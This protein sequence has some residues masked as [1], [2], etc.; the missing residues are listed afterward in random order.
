MLTRDELAAAYAPADRRMPHVRMNFVTSLDGAATLG[1][2]SGALGGETDRLLMGVLR[3]QCDVLLVG[4]G[5]I[6]AEGYG[7][8]AVPEAEALVRE[9][10]GLDAQPRVAVVSRTLELSPRH[11][12]FAD[13]VT[14]PLVVTC[15]A[16]SAE[17][18]A[19]LAA[20]ADVIVAGSD[21][22][23]LGVALAELT[24]RGL[25][26]VLCEG[27]P[28]L[29]GSLLAAGLVDEVCLTVSPHL[30][31]GP[32]GRIVAGAPEAARGMRL[33]HALTDGD[34]LF[35]RYVAH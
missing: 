15:A 35:L 9:A 6:R 25:S 20:V 7:G 13:A 10:A 32:A 28:H 12:F 33:Q 19:A 22:V 14:R 4:A 5:T 11:P 24:A 26:R 17:R 8:V 3:G 29:F 1:G 2:R 31:G 30:V 18:R 21:D 34:W 27:G 23:D 16:A